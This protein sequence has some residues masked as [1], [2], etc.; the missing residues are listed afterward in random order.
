MSVML[1]IFTVFMSVANY[2]EEVVYAATYRNGAQSGPST[3]YKNGK[4]Y[5][6]Y[7][8]V[9]ITGDNRT[10]LIAIALSQLGYQE[11]A[12][13]GNFSGEV[14]GRYNYVEYSYNLGDLGLGYGGSDYPWCASFVTWCLYQ[15]R[16]TNQATYS[17]LGRFHVGD[18]DYIWKEI[19][20]SQWVR[21]LKGAG[22]YKY[23]KYEGG[24]Y[25]PQSGD[26]VFFQNSGGVAHIGICLYT[27][28]GRIYT[29]EGNTSD[30]SGLEANGGGVYF[31][32]Y[33]LSSSYLN[34]YGVLPYKS[35]SSVVKIDY[36]GNNPTT[37][38]YVSNASKYI[39]STSTAT[40]YSSVL[41]RFA[42]FEVTEVCSNG[43]LKI[44]YGDVVG[45]INNNSDR[46][47]QLSST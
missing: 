38:L 30:S 16:C 1:S 34:G 3:S 46:V 6:H 40:S 12:A 45:Y 7:T 8:Q 20:C 25:T 23:S 42:M 28:G 24:S 19:S 27:S 2:T 39:Y 43:R 17:S 36:S 44:K 37:G 41:P 9:P 35:D 15:S 14:S 10:D 22:Y 11:G 32:N 33:S 18:Y 21:Q 47:I 29:V 5:K 4:Y 31:K 26:L 13:N